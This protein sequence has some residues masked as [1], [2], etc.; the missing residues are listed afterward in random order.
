MI[1]LFSRIIKWFEPSMQS[2]L[3]QYIC[4]RNP[5]SAGDLDKLIQEFSYKKQGGWL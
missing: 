5:Q 3:E 4:I 1:T 2:E